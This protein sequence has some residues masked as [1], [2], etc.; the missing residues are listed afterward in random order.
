[1]TDRPKSVQRNTPVP[2]TRHGLTPGQWNECN[3]TPLGQVFSFDS[4]L[5]VEC[6]EISGCRVSP[7]C[8]HLSWNNQPIL[9]TYF[10]NYLPISTKATTVTLPVTYTYT[11]PLITCHMGRA[12]PSGEVEGT[13][14]FNALVARKPVASTG[15]PLVRGRRGV[16]QLLAGYFDWLPPPEFRRSTRPVVSALK[17]GGGGAEGGRGGGQSCQPPWLRRSATFVIR[18]GGTSN[19]FLANF[20]G[21]ARE[22]GNMKKQFN[23]MRQLANQTVGRWVLR[24][25]RWTFVCNNILILA[26]GGAETVEMSRGLGILGI[27]PVVCSS[28][29]HGRKG[30]WTPG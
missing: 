9:N 4:F 21:G 16:Q 29:C 12:A 8:P 14:S 6:S 20:Q 22:G 30:G 10:L 2:R 3:H 27:F 18:G 19:F 26:G 5:H 17:W 24:L 23:R 25:R 13:S 28:M 11:P 15:G 1:M 7:I